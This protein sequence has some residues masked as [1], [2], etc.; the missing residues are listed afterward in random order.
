LIF[1]LFGFV[2]TDLLNTSELTSTVAMIAL[3]KQKRFGKTVMEG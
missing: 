3:R 1:A 2:L